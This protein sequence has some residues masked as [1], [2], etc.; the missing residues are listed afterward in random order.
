LQI[1]RWLAV[2]WIP[3]S[4]LK[5]HKTF[6]GTKTSLIIGTSDLKKLGQGQSLLSEIKLADCEVATVIFLKVGES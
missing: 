4:R 1:E 3:K 5:L 6:R 2:I